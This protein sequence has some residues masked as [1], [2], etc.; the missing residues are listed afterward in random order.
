[1]LAEVVQNTS[2]LNALVGET[3]ARSVFLFQ[4][5]SVNNKGYE[6]GNN[7]WGAEFGLLN[8]N[9]Q[10]EVYALAST[11]NGKMTWGDPGHLYWA[12]TA[13]ETARW[14]FNTAVWYLDV[15]QPTQLYDPQG[16]RINIYR[17]TL[18][19]SQRV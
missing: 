8:P 13:Q 7:S 17:G 19:V 14:I 1:M 6:Y 15:V 9:D 10:N 12:F 11:L 3:Y 16:T 4:S 2:V 18:T 5:D